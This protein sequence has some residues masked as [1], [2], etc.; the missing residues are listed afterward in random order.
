M[1]K[2]SVFGLNLVRMI[3]RCCMVYE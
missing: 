1:G 2:S 3:Y